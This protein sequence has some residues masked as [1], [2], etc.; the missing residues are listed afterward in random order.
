MST[1]NEADHPRVPSGQFAPKPE[2]SAGV[3]LLA[4]DP[5]QGYHVDTSWP[6]PQAND[7]DK[8]MLASDVVYAGVDTA[9]G[10]AD[11][12]GVSE[13]EGA[14]YAD[15]AGYLGLIGRCNSG[16][17]KG[18][19][20]T[21]LGELMAQSGR[22]EKTALLARMVSMSPIVAMAADADEGDPMEGLA[23][24]TRGRRLATAESWLRQVTDQ[25]GLGAAF[26]HVYEHRAAAVA[27]AVKRA[28]ADREARRA[29]QTPAVCPTCWMALPASGVCGTC[30][31]AA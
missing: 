23:D 9:R 21:A 10:V 28:A 14:Y 6:V 20:P 3:A 17:V 15:A 30:E 7:L 24:S 19:E 25:D 31:D 12:L 18:Y 16:G 1:F 13:R 2:M 8:V 5:L 22:S 27:D 4:P 29:Q 26:E 11:A